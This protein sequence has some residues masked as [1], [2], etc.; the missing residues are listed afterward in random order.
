MCNLVDEPSQDV[1]LGSELI[2]LRWSQTTL[3][4]DTLQ[5]RQLFGRIV[6]TLAKLVENLNVVLGILVLSI[7]LQAGS[8]RSDLRSYF[9]NAST[10][11]EF[12]D[13]AVQSLNSAGSSGQTTT[14]GA[15]GASFGVDELNE[16]L[17]RTSSLVWLG[18]LGAFR[19]ELDGRVGAHALVLGG[20]LR[21]LCFGVDLGD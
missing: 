17:F 10:A 15:V 1:R 9:S 14:N 7:I 16:V 13:K 8:G 6:V 19:K 5:S 3:L 21:V 18:S 2:K 4:D 20:G 12:L 11:S